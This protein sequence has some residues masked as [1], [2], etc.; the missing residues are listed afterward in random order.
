MPPLLPLF[1]QPR[2][3]QLRNLPNAEMNPNCFSLQSSQLCPEFHLFEVPA[4]PEFTTVQEF[5]NYLL[6]SLDNSTAFISGFASEYECNQFNGHGIRYHLS[7][8][9]NYFVTQGVQRCP[10][11]IGA[12]VE[13][14]PLCESTC[15]AHIESILNIFQT[16][17]ICSQQPSDTASSARKSYLQTYGNA[18]ELISSKDE[19]FCSK[20]V[21]SD[22]VNSGFSFTQ[23]AAGVQLSTVVVQNKQEQQ[24]PHTFT[25]NN[26][27]R[28][29]KLAFILPARDYPWM[30]SGA[31][32]AV[33][34]NGFIVWLYLQAFVIDWGS[35]STFSV[36]P[37]PEGF[38]EAFEGI[39]RERYGRSEDRKRQSLFHELFGSPIEGAS[40]QK[41]VREPMGVVIPPRRGFY[42]GAYRSLA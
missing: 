25:A 10:A 17:A 1:K 32:W 31:A 34:V 36:A 8:M 5:D 28:A 11:T 2:Q 33:G 27:T 13:H 29:Q 4:S 41:S 40:F 23:D 12:P 22:V 9:C 21:Y 26:W 3:Q 15:K 18:C 19:S 35:Y 20:G 14:K 6:E 42:D 24:Q 16:S 37:V 7:F 30:L 38:V 39:K